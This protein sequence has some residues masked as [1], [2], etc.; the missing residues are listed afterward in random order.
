FIWDEMM[1]REQSV[2]QITVDTTV[3]LAA[4]AAATVRMRLGALVTPVP[5]RRPWKLARE[6]ATLDHLLGGRMVMGVGLG[7]DDSGQFSSFGEP[8]EDTLHAEQLEEAL[9]IITGL[10]SGEPLSYA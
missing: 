4:M 3:A 8:V 9:G 10:W 7:G 2:N 1:W 6:L 5:R